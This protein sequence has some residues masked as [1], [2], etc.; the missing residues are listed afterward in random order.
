MSFKRALSAFVR[1]T[2][3]LNETLPFATRKLVESVRVF[4]LTKTV[5]RI[6]TFARSGKLPALIGNRRTFLL[7]TI[8]DKNSDALTSF[9]PRTQSRL[10]ATF[11][12][13]RVLIVAELSIPQC[14][15][16]RV[17]QKAELFGKIGIETEIVDWT[18]LDTVRTLLQTYPVVIFYR[19]PATPEIILIIQEAKRLG[20]H[21]FWEVDDLV[22]DPDGYL[23]NRNLERLNPEIRAGVISGMKLYREALLL[24]DEGIGSTPLLA[25]AKTQITGKPAYVVENALDDETIKI[26]RRI[27]DTKKPF[28]RSHKEVTIV[29]GSGTKTHDIDFLSASEALYNV[30]SKRPNVKLRIIGELNIESRF[31]D[32]SDRI[33][34]LPFTTFNDYL[35]KVADADIS[36]APLEQTAFN[37][38]KSNIKFL[39]ASVLGLPSVCSPADAFRSA[40]IDGETGFMATSSHEWEYKLVALVDDQA[41]RAEMAG[42]AFESVNRNY[43]LERIAQQ[44]LAPIIGRFNNR[45]SMVTRILF[46]N[47]Y[48]APQSF[49]GATIVAEEMAQRLAKKEN[50]EVYVFTSWSN[51]GA[52]DYGIVRYDA[53]GA[54]VFAV[55]TPMIRSRLMDV[56]DDAMSQVFQD[57][58]SAIKPDV[59]QLHSIQTLGVTLGSVCKAA[60]IPYAITLHD[61]WWLC[62]RQFM[63]TGEGKYCFQTWIDPEV[64]ARCVPD[65]D[66]NKQRTAIVR[67]GLFQA[68]GLISP[69]HFFKQL[70]MDNGLDDERIFVNKNGIKVPSSTYKRRPSKRIRFGY[71]GGS[72]PIKGYELVRKAFCELPECGIELVMVDNTLNHGYSSVNAKGFNAGNPVRIVPAYSQ[73]TIDEF[74]SGIDVLLFP[75]QWKESF[76]LTVREALI[77]DVWVIATDAGGAVEDLVPG[78][79]GDIIPISNDSVYLRKSMEKIVENGDF[80]KD[81][82]NPYK[83]RIRTFDGQADELLA[84]LKSLIKRSVTA[85]YPLQHS[86]EPSPL[87]DADS[88]TAQQPDSS[89]HLV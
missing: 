38:A 71:V 36:I 5:S 37:D 76:G 72:T 30:L 81:Y 75:S 68:D 12:T 62:E 50:V 42:K 57:V 78:E 70:Y 33:E 21:T 85:A 45:I 66:F 17:T 25:K 2:Q 24:C 80:L 53:K 63:V 31:N 8:N 28:A 77:R 74:F 69:S 15:K 60:G 59:V 23:S 46:A 1:K 27:Q 55:K 29:Y 40:I 58:L 39:E 3:S 67:G 7:S 18:H 82:S 73:D 19:V 32:F 49:G 87:L 44:Q 83:D 16:Y 52:P 41:L 47:V 34:R 13:P 61:A 9:Y 4:G 26:A 89:G 64:C 35:E 43:S 88:M 51:D 79:N 14:K 6:F 84:Y 48:F 20:V 22:F 54:T 56:E 65:K 11:M 86:G 10:A